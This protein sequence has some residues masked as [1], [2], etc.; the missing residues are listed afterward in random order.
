MEPAGS[1][2][3]DAA[4]VKPC[5]QAALPGPVSAPHGDGA[6]LVADQVVCL[7][8]SDLDDAAVLQAFRQDPLAVGVASPHCDGAV[9]IADQVVCLPGGDLDDVAVLQAFRQAPLTV[10]VASPGCDCGRSLD[11]RSSVAC[12]SAMR[13][14]CGGGV[15]RFE[16][17]VLRDGVFGVSSAVARGLPA[18]ADSH[19]GGSGKAGHDERCY[20]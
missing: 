1:Y 9:R 4:V 15:V 12:G 19:D 17:G 5:G 20:C 8:G 2:L 13:V 7:S 18:G 11:S 6:V 16:D 14:V 3:D 10:C